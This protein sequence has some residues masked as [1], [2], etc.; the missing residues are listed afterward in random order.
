MNNKC[1]NYLCFFF[2]VLI[3]TGIFPSSIHAQNTNLKSIQPVIRSNN[4]AVSCKFNS[5][6]SDASLETLASGMSSTLNFHLQL[7]QPGSDVLWSSGK[8]VKIQ[9]NVWEKKY[10][11]AHSRQNSE[12]SDYNKFQNFLHDSLEF[13]IAASLRFQ[14]SLKLQ[15][16]LNFLPEKMSAG[17]KQKLDYWIENESDTKESRPAGETE[18][19]FSI[20]LSRLI[21]MFFGKTEKTKMQRIKSTAFIIKSLRDDENTTR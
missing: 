20:N 7:I 15:I 21:T 17:Q 1:N 6:I 4:L 8:S 10:S 16:V 5:L 2:A 19:G 14:S 9:Y 3:I 11:I 18:S 12:F 13:K